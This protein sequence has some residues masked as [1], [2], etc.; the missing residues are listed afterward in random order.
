MGYTVD[1]TSEKNS[2]CAVLVLLQRVVSL[3]FSLMGFWQQKNEVD[4]AAK[5]VNVS[6]EP[7]AIDKNNQPV[8]KERFSLAV[9]WTISENRKMIEKSANVESVLTAVVKS[10]SIII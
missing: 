7:R 6:V 5:K 3:P 9:A 8:A 2:L 1:G 4:I 10:V